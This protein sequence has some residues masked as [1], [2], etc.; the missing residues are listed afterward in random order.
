M[1]VSIETR[2]RSATRSVAAERPG[3]SM[4]LFDKVLQGMVHTLDD[5]FGVALG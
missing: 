4:L 1:L 5:P 3:A 2:P